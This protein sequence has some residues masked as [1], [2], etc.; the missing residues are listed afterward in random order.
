MTHKSFCQQVREDIYR[1]LQD[2]QDIAFKFIAMYFG[3]ARGVKTKQ[4]ITT[5]EITVQ[6][7]YYYKEF[8]SQARASRRLKCIAFVLFKWDMVC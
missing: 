4:G 7:S 1:Y 3:A 5:R 2:V 6:C 8:D